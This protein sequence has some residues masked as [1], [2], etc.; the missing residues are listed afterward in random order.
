MHVCEVVD[1]RLRSY[2]IQCMEEAST[3]HSSSEDELRVDSMEKKVARKMSVLESLAHLPHR[4]TMTSEAASRGT[5]ATANATVAAASTTKAA[6]VA[7]QAAAAAH[8]DAGKHDVVVVISEDEGPP[9]SDK[10][11]ASAKRRVVDQRLQ[12]NELKDKMPSMGDCNAGA[13]QPYEHHRGID[14]TLSL[15]HI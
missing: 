4:E 12:S 3:D 1:N 11:E 13:N 7:H 15:I 14:M 6:A 10:P 5:E 8:D 9:N 2:D